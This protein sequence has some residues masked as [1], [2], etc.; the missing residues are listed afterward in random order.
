[1]QLVLRA[2]LLGFACVLVAGCGSSAQPN[3]TGGGD[4]PIFLALI[5]VL[6]LTVY[7]GIPSAV[8]FL[9]YRLVRRRRWCYQGETGEVGTFSKYQLHQLYQTGRITPQTPIRQVRDADWTTGVAIEGPPRR[10]GRGVCFALLSAFFGFWLSGL[11]FGESKSFDQI[12]SPPSEEVLRKRYHAEIAADAT[13]AAAATSIPVVNTLGEAGNVIAEG[14]AERINRELDRLDKIRTR[15]VMST[16]LLALLGG[17]AGGAT[18]KG[19]VTIHK[20][21]RPAVKSP[22]PGPPTAHSPVPPSVRPPNPPPVSPPGRPPGQWP[23][24]GRV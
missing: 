18:A 1:M 16:A 13:G 15:I 20:E 2:A 8:V 7:I 11:L 5:V 22:P 19:P 6:V 17:L 3:Q 24:G 9:I 12:F 4:S 10:L 14:V 21:R 23:D